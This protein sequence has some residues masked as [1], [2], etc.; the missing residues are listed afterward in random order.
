MRRSRPVRSSRA[1]SRTRRPGAAVLLV[2]AI[3]VVLAGWAGAQVLQGVVRPPE[4]VPWAR[5]GTQDVHTLRPIDPLA[6]QLLFGHHDGVMAS[7]DGGRTWTALPVS[8]DAMGMAPAPDG[9]IVIAGHLVLEESRD[10]GMTWASLTA[11]LPSLDIHAFARSLTDPARMWAYLAE[12]GLY[13]ST[14]GGS[15][16]ASVFDGHVIELTAV[17]EDGA[18][19]LVGVDPFAGL[20][21]SRDGGRSWQPVGQPPA[22]PVLSL[23][24]TPDGRIMV[25]GGTDG[26]HRSEDG[27]AT[28]HRVLE[29]APVLAAAT[30][31]DGARVMAVTEGALYYRSDDGG[32][33]WPA[34]PD[35]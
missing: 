18:D 7:D 8:Q 6:E 12:G 20:V 33:S 26:L 5:L 10:G 4:A 9:S 3:V 35:G 22:A 11:D 1:P 32:A 31:A 19:V 23:G 2:V 27:G 17:R 28:W 14:D 13:E 34:P 25:I 24:A 15:R 30:S 16:W 29:T 21:R